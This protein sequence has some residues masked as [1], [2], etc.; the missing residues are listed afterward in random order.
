M[1]MQKY[2]L[3]LVLYI[4]KSLIE[5]KHRWYLYSN[6]H[7]KFVCGQSIV[8]LWSLLKQYNISDFCDILFIA[9][10]DILIIAI[11]IMTIYTLDMDFYMY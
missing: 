4:F 8:I 11:C 3:G 5:N 9:F 7:S 10:S 1:S 2:I 6:L